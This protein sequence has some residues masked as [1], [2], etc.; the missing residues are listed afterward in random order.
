[1]DEALYRQIG[2]ASHSQALVLMGDFKYPA[3]AGGTTQQVISNPGGFWSAL[4][5]TS[6]SPTMRGSLRM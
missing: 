2:G 5:M 6:Q 1:V 4:M 3:T